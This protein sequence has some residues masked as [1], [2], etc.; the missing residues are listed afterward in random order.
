MVSVRLVFVSYIL[1]EARLSFFIA[2]SFLVGGPMRRDIELRTRRWSIQHSA[3][4]IARVSSTSCRS[5]CLTIT[6]SS[7]CH[8]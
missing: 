4:R 1:R 2:E 5:R 6:Y 7:M 3:L 8:Y